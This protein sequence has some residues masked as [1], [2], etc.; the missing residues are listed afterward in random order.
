MRWVRKNVFGMTQE[1]LAEVGGVSRPRVCRYESQGEPPPYDFL[2]RIRDHA[3]AEGLQFD[4]DWLFEVPAEASACAAA[5]AR[6]PEDV[7]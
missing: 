3:R 2:K 4:A 5:A 7:Q 1:E 6:V